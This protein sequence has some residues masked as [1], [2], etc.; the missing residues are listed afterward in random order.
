MQRTIH[1]RGLNF[2]ETYVESNPE[3][4]D[5]YQFLSIQHEHPVF[6][7][8]KFRFWYVRISLQSVVTQKI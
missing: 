6:Q 7:N 4:G 2:L 1:E 8:P 3:F 5:F